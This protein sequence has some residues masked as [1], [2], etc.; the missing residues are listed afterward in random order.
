MSAPARM[1]NPDVDSTDPI[2]DLIHSV[3]GW[4]IDAEQTPL[5]AFC[6]RDATE[7][8]FVETRDYGPQECSMCVHELAHRHCPTCGRRGTS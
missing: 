6:G 3:C 5:L 2:D 1:F 7:D 8:V 4:C